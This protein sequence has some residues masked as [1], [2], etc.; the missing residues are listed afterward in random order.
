ML[1]ERR[2]GSPYQVMNP[3]Q[4]KVRESHKRQRKKETIDTNQASW[5][6]LEMRTVTKSFLF[7]LLP[8][9]TLQD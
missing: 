3:I 7:S 4:L 5:P 2:Y 8:S 9:A 1:Q 6:V